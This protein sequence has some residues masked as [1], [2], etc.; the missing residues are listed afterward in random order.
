MTELTSLLRLRDCRVGMWLSVR[1]LQ[2]MHEVIEIRRA[3]RPARHRL[4]ERL[5]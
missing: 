3:H 2:L 1:A 5:S 4:I